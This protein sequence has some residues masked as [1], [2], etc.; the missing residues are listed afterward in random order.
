MREELLDILHHQHHV[1]SRH[2]P[3][4][5]S[6]RASKFSSYKALEGHEQM[7]AEEGRL[8]DNL[9][10]L[11]DDEMDM[12]NEKLRILLEHEYEDMRAKIRYFRHDSRKCG[13]AYLHF[14]GTFRYYRADVNRLVFTDNSE[15]DVDVISDIDIM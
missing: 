14:T 2:M 15:I 9:S 1:S 5:A 8:T 3:M 13:G 11:T 7:I 10:E 6:S 12:L 4:S